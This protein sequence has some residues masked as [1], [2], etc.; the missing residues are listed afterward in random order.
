M[1]EQ[2]GVPSV[3][4]IRKGY[5][6]ALIAKGQRADGRKFDEQRGV[7]IQAGLIN[8]AEGSAQV[9]LGN[10]TVMAGVKMELG[11]P[12]PDSPDK[13]TITTGS[14][15]LPMASPGFDAGA[16]SPMS[17]EL[18]RVV[19]RGVRESDCIDLKGLCVEAGKKV[20]TVYIDLHVLD[21]DGNLMDAA[22][23]AAIA[24]LR[25]TTVRASKAGL[26]D[27]YKLPV[28]GIPIPVTIVKVGGALLADPSLDEE[29]IAE[30]RLTVTT[31]ENGAIRAMQKGLTG[32]FT[33][34]EVMKVV[35][36]SKRL[37][38]EMRGRI[39]GL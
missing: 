32:S 21:F 24:A 9:K 10:T 7:S 12:Y 31:D 11:A 33:K 6:E 22:G 5:L 28:K 17:I 29:R 34:D 38:D 37:G 30:A 13:G 27:D 35:A 15:L 2:Q 4:E 16:P 8:V 3:P 36:L 39:K 14:E 23:L 25:N 18:S 26:G 19:D 20:W 1:A